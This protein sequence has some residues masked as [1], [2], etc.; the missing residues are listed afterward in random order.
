[1]TAGIW[2]LASYPKSGSTWLRAFLATLV[3]GQPADINRLDILGGIS[4]SRFGFDD[5]L[6]IAAAD[7]SLEQQTDLRPRA[8]EIWAAQAQRPIYCKTHDA[9]HVTP[10]GEPLF[11]T[12]VTRGAVYVVRD[13]RAI[14]VSLAHHTGRTIDAEIARMDDPDAAFSGSEGRLHQQLHQR[15]QRWNEHVE[16]WLRAPFP[17]HLLRYED[18]HGDPHAAFGGAAAFLGLASDPAIVAAAVA[19]TAFARLQAQERASGFVERPHQA[20]VFFR[21]GRIDGWRQVLT[22]EQNARIV[23][24]HGAVMRKLGYDL[25]LAPFAAE[26]GAA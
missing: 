4:S 12:A 1:V 7:L 26:R 11:P 9:Y 8:Y 18:M 15:L 20:A 21:E 13:P 24:A 6:G 23:A 17:L 14:A 2:W 25:T 3:S 5:A 22:P 16:S 10:S 19:A